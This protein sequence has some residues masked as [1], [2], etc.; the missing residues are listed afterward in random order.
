MGSVPPAK[1]LSGGAHNPSSQAG[2]MLGL[3][4]GNVL[5]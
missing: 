1:A 4:H 3:G 2:I 5:L